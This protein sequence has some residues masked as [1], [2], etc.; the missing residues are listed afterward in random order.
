MKAIPQDSSRG[1]DEPQLPEKEGGK[2]GWVGGGG[3]EQT[4]EA[5]VAY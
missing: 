2:G 5:T 4:V 3:C 1:Y